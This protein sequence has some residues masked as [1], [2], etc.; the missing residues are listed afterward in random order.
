MA[1]EDAVAAHEDAE[2]ARTTGQL[3]DAAVVRILERI[4]RE[5]AADGRK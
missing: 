4:E 2:R 5:L 3:A 1:H